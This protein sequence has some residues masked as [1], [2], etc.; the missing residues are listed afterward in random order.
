[1][2]A[3]PIENADPMEDRNVQLEKTL[4]EEYLHEKGYTL[5][6]LKELPVEVIEK[7][8]KDASQYASLRMEEVHARAQ[9]IKELHED[10]SPLKKP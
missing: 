5:N 10:A 2:C 9:F 3:K 1:M 8:M 4:I 6:N 7:L